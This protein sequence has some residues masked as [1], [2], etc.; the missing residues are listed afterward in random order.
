MHT[1][2]IE[3]LESIRP[4]LKAYALNLT[5]NEIDANDLI[6]DTFLKVLSHIDKFEKNT[7]FKAWATTIMR[8]HFLNGCRKKLNRQTFL[9]DTPGQFYINQGQFDHNNGESNI[10]YDY[11]V[12]MVRMLPENE[13]L[14]FWMAYQGYQ[15]DEIATQLE[16]PLGTIKSRI[17]WAKRKL[18]KM[19]RKAN[20]MVEAA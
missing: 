20:S 18:Q 4:T 8:N 15:Y 7:D 16:A 10:G 12:N 9:D 1:P 2:L 19:Y 6:Q 14:A 3:Q 13:R 11:L 17:F 5:R